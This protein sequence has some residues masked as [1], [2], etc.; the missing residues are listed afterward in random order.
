MAADIPPRTL[1]YFLS[2]VPWDHDRLRD[3]IQWQVA[4]EQSHPRAIGVIDE[5]G[6][7]KKGKYTCGVKRQW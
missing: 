7:P 2:D 4:T 1:Q 6:S 3:R 5:S